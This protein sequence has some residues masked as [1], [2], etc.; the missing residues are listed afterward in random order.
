MEEITFGDEIPCVDEIAAAMG[1]SKRLDLSRI[2]AFVIILI[3]K[4]ERNCE[5]Y[6]KDF[7]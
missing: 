4:A 6:A 5:L 1:G 3:R 7:R 2:S